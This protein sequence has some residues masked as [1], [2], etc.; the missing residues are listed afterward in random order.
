MNPDEYCQHKAL[1]SGSSVYYAMLFLQPER[2][3]AIT[4]L[5][6]FCR[7]VND[8]VDECADTGVAYA[9]LAWWRQE[10]VRLDAGAPQHPVTRALLPALPAFGIRCEHLVEVIDGVEMDLTRNRYLDFPALQKRCQRTAGVASLLAATVLGYRDEQTPNYARTLGLAFQLTH[11]IRNV[12][13]D[14]RKGRIY[15]P[16]SE[17]QQFKVS[18]ADILHA[19]Q[20]ENF[21]R[22]MAFQIERTERYYVSALEQLSA[23]DRKSQ[24]PGLIMTAINR[25][26]LREIEAEGCKV[27]VQRT[28]LTPVRKLWIAWKTRVNA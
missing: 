15:L 22:L 23:V 8:I 7:E 6:A 5:C 27:L 1:R 19:R 13:E 16:M 28:A 25:A 12:G 2:R 20:S 26:L 18:A 3:R 11:V 17:L 4:A 21:V 14:S 24:H 9:K 10:L